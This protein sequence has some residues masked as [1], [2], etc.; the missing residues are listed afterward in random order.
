MK[1]NADLIKS[2]VS[3]DIGDVRFDDNVFLSIKKNNEDLVLILN[4]KRAYSNFCKNI[5]L[6]KEYGVMNIP[7]DTRLL[8]TLE[9]RKNNWIL[10]DNNLN[11]IQCFD[12]S[13]YSRLCVESRERFFRDKERW[14]IGELEKV[15]LTSSKLTKTVKL[16]HNEGIH[17]NFKYS[18]RRTKEFS[19][20]VYLHRTK[21]FVHIRPEY[22]E[23][24]PLENRDV[25]F[26]S[27]HVTFNTELVYLFNKPNDSNKLHLNTVFNRSWFY[28]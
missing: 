5:H 13:N 10:T 16:I 18:I 12:D 24:S 6:Q 28:K 26:R 14:T 17:T 3:F 20:K 27:A 22:K 25:E 9:D 4:N 19:Q 21:E 8:Q 1:Y 23:Y 11:L 7:T 2:F 15:P